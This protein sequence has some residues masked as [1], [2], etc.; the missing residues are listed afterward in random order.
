ML[1]IK[2]YFLSFA[3]CDDK[4]SKYS[5]I[6]VDAPLIGGRGEGCVATHLGQQHDAFPG[7]SS[8]HDSLWTTEPRTAEGGYGVLSASER[9]VLDASYL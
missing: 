9:A 6:R 5:T 4:G 2:F 7:A 1:H 3:S 8:G